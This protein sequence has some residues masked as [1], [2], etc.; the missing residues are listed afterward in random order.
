MV[1][2]TSESAS[3]LAEID[4]IVLACEQDRIPRIHE[5]IRFDLAAAQE[6]LAY[7]W[8]CIQAGGADPIPQQL[9]LQSWAALNW[10][11]SSLTGG[12]DAG[13]NRIGAGTV[14]HRATDF[15]ECILLEPLGTAFWLASGS[16]V[17]FRE[18]FRR[19]LSV[20]GMRSK[21]TYALCGALEE[22]ANNSCEH[23]ASERPPLVGAQVTPGGWQFAVTDVGIGVLASLR[24]NPDF[25]DL[26]A[27]AQALEL[28]LKDGVSSIPQPG[29]GRGFSQV[30][31]ALVDSKASLRFRSRGVTASWSGLS[32]TS[33]SLAFVSLPVGRLRGFHV[34]VSGRF[35]P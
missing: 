12:G 16:F 18:R 28:A 10:L 11:I 31:K 1:T 26:K 13:T 21:L 5:G 20:S 15:A 4:R 9:G 27:E 3:V 19:A 7:R 22:M 23:S 32:P 8:S 35:S 25:S 30:F 33:Q 29:R 2:K 34:Q 17:R 6:F 14:L 24:Q